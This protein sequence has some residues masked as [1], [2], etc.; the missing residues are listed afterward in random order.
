MKKKLCLRFE[1]LL[2]Q[3]VADSASMSPSDRKFLKQHRSICSDCAQE[4]AVIEYLQNELSVEPDK[5]LEHDSTERMAEA[6]L[7]KEEER[8]Q[9]RQQRQDPQERKYFRR[10][11]LAVSGSVA[12]ILALILI[13][14]I[15]GAE[16]QRTTHVETVKLANARLSLVSGSVYVGS[17][18]IGVGETLQPGIPLTTKDG[19]AIVS[20]PNS[21]TAIVERN[22]QLLY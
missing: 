17:D 3:W 9:Q 19:L 11:I 16:K 21:N 5:E 15:D 12:V 13:L 20:L 10:S 1:N 7:Q 4:L 14:K 2:D 6:V 18:P 8:R 22:T